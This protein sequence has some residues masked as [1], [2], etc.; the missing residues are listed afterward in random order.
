MTLNIDYSHLYYAG[1]I[2]IAVLSFLGKYTY[3]LIK[4]V[5]KEG[6]SLQKDRERIHIMYQQLTPNHGTSLSDKVNVLSE[7]FSIL[8]SDVECVKKDVKRNNEMTE[9]LAAQ[10]NWV[11]ERQK[12]PTFR[13]D[14]NGSCIWVSEDYAQLFGRSSSYFMGNGWKNIIY[15]EDRAKVEE[16]WQKCIEDKIDSE[17]V[18]RA[19]T[20]NDKVVKVKVVANRI[21]N[22]SYIGTIS[23][24]GCDDPKNCKC[25]HN[26]ICKKQV[27]I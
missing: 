3:K 11:L 1:A 12:V 17:N 20:A 21:E 14:E 27:V 23:L 9:I 18:F 15:S 19:I 13:S 2:V 16:H 5:K 8:K 24:L 25:L 22:G 10:Q 4:W 7:N 6:S 26:E